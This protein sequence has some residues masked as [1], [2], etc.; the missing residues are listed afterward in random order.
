MLL[1]TAT[2]VSELCKV[3]LSDVNRE[4]RTFLVQSTGGIERFLTL[5]PNGWY[6]LL[7]YLEQSR[8]MGMLSGRWCR[9]GSPLPLR[10]VSTTDDQCHHALV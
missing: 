2:R 4:Q 5:S 10:V 3:C 8:P 7:S 6:Q 1:D 9:G